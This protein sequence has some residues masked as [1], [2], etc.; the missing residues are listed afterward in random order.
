M[1][2]IDEKIPVTFDEKKEAVWNEIVEVRADG[3]I[4]M[5][6][7]RP[8]IASIEKNIPIPNVSRSAMEKGKPLPAGRPLKYP[9][10]DMEAGDSFIVMEAEAYLKIT[11]FLKAPEIPEHL[12]RSN[13]GQL[14]ALRQTVSNSARL[15]AERNKLDRKFTVRLDENDNLRC[16]RIA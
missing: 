1:T 6:I 16:W 5:Q 15:W 9:F 8:P 14:Q 2:K 11:S 13:A 4:D 7:Y 10:P 12:K 3:R